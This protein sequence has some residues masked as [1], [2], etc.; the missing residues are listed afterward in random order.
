MNE[1]LSPDETLDSAERQL[2]DEL[3]LTLAHPGHGR[4]AHVVWEVVRSLGEGDR[5]LLI[6]PPALPALPGRQIQMRFAH[7]QLAQELAKGT[8]PSE[9]ALVT[10][11]STSYISVL[12]ASPAFQELL[13]TYGA[14][15]EAVFVDAV[16]RMKSLG[17]VALE[18]LQQRLAE[19]P[20]QFSKKELQDMVELLLVKP[21]AGPG[22]AGGTPAPGGVA[23]NISFVQ[24][25]ESGKLV[26][27]NSGEVIPNGI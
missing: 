14:E 25:K 12:K 9:A 1:A 20:E 4:N 10:G 23:V 3:E 16:Q 24:G 5:E 22:K 17:L 11:F 21:N 8:T 7:H 19:S 13:A 18:E 6:H 26:D 2:L 27:N 15:R